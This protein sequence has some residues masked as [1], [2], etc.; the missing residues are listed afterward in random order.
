ML[1][2]MVDKTAKENIDMIVIDVMVTTELGI[3]LEKGHSQEFIVVIELEVQAVVG[4]G[5]DPEPV[6][7]GIE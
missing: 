7:I 3:D 4:L 6:L 1:G 2:D 5:Q